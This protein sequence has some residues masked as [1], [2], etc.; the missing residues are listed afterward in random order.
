MLRTKSY[1]SVAVTS[2]DRPALLGALRERVRLLVEKQPEIVEVLLYGSVVRGDQTPESDID[3]LIVVEA[4]ELPFLE[5]A[6]P[7]LRMFAD[8]PLDVRPVIYT[9]QELRRGLTEGNPF[10]TTVLPEALQIHSTSGA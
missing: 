4:S 5:R 7:Y 1:G 10:L 3:L 6:D 2:V 9:R 8:F